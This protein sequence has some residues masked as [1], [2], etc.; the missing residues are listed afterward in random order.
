MKHYKKYLTGLCC[1]AALVFINPNITH[2][3]INTVITGKIQ[4]SKIDSVYIYIDDNAKNA[5]YKGK[6]KI[7]VPVVSNNFKL[8]LHL[9]HPTQFLIKLKNEKICFISPGDS[10]HLSVLTS[11]DDTVILSGSGYQ[12]TL[13]ADEITQAL[14][15]FPKPRNRSFTSC[16]SLE[17]YLDFSGNIDLREEKADLMLEQ[18]KARLASKAE[19]NFLRAE[20]AGFL[21]NYRTNKFVSLLR[22]K[23]EFGLSI[24]DLNAVYDSTITNG[25]TKKI[26]ISDDLAFSGEYLFHTY[27]LSICQFCKEQNFE[28]GC[29]EKAFY[30][31][32]YKTVQKHYTGLLKER[33]TQNILEHAISYYKTDDTMLQYILNDYFSQK[34]FKEY[35]KY[36]KDLLA[37]SQTLSVGEA[38]PRFTLP[39]SDNKWID[40]KDLKGKVV[41]MDFWF[42]GCSPCAALVPTMEKI[43]EYY[44]GNA[45]LVMLNISIDQRDKWLK[46]VK[47]KI[48]TVG[49]GISAYTMGA[50]KNHSVIKNY[51]A[52][53]PKLIVIGRDGNIYNAHMPRTES[54]IKA[55]LDSALSV[56]YQYK[57]VNDIPSVIKNEQEARPKLVPVVFDDH[58]DWNFTV[59]LKSKLENE[60][61]DYPSAS[62]ILV[63]SDIEGNYKAFRKLLIA[64][65]VIDEQQNWTYGIGHLVL[66]GD[67]FDRGDHVTEVL[68]LIYKLEAEAEK[69]GGK[70]HFILGNH[71]M[72]N[73]SGDYRYVQQ[74]YFDAAEIQGLTYFDLYSTN[75][76]LGK[77]LRTKNIIEK[78]GSNLFVHGGISQFVNKLQLTVAEINKTARPFYE[79]AQL[80]EEKEGDTIGVIFDQT[81]GP[82]WYRGLYSNATE[83]QV[84]STLNMFSVKHIV[85]GHTVVESI[86]TK[87]NNKVINT[88]TKHAEGKSEALF[89]ENNNF[90]SMNDQ[91]QTWLLFKE[92]D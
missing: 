85:T 26:K 87:F 73:L 88:D 42:T 75:T 56:N 78:I 16:D 77:W 13:V 10:I 6:G 54:G 47:D 92:G 44:K 60:I 8:P 64:G 53:Y 68:W 91:G 89:I 66:T 34:D 4:D 36:S 17:D 41:I 84:D 31:G 67:F 1:I 65:K 7:A 2:S 38:A 82:L 14:K 62:K 32:M 50:G 12:K 90:Y 69:A 3:Q 5:N 70:V 21:E 19:L 76:E 86:S 74:K 80:I 81:V 57:K 35:K 55:V 43:H 71:E 40:L 33:S 37:R 45:D 29:T 39:T 24:K 9:D 51:L 52:R 48:F 58:Q 83:T 25:F 18:N 61:A 20:I 22:K 23:K 15:S 63:I 72:M 49:E 11:P 27:P 59:S 79:K 28:D 46:S 30:H